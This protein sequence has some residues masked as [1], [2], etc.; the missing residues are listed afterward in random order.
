MT[1]TNVAPVPTI[2]GAPSTSPEGTPISLTSTV[3]DPGTLDTQTY[4]WTVTKGG[5][6]YPTGTPTNGGGF[7]FTPDDNGTYVVSLK[8]TDKDGGTNTT[9]KTI[10]VTNVAPTVAIAGA[11]A[12]SPEGSPISLGSTV[13]DPGILDILTYTWTVKV[14]ATTV[15]TQTGVDLT[16]FGFTPADNGSYDVTL[17]VNDGVATTTATKTIV[18][19]NVAPV[20]T[21][22]NAPA[23]SPEGTAIALT[24]SA[25]DPG[26]LDNVTLTWSVT[27]DGAAYGTSGTGANYSFTPNDNGT[28]VVSLTAKDKDNATTTAAATIQVTN[29]APSFTTAPAAQGAPEGTATPFA[30]GS[31]ADPGSVDGPWTVVV[32]WGDGKTDTFT[33]AAAGSL[34]SLNHTYA[35]DGSYTATVSVTDKDGMTGSATFGAIVAN[36]APT[37]N[38]PA[39]Q[40]ATEGT[41]ATFALGGF[42]DPGADGPWTVTVA[43]GDG[44]TDTFQADAP[45]SLGSLATL[46]PTAGPPSTPPP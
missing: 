22:A 17:D 32:N 21:I 25:I 7:A 8:V 4:L 9:T 6:A 31:F 10:T 33:V 1:V 38:P 19:T 27:K 30:L 42:A 26:T 11:P 23:S 41:S 15:A 20:A 2:L 36:V 13:T 18:V 29:V 45:G 39:D 34:G 28:Y 12:T 46:T 43:W 44:K 37:V 35:Q 14:G 40:T 3:V 5:S 16:A 24:G